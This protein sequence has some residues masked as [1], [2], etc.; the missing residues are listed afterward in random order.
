MC[1]ESTFYIDTKVEIKS[2]RSALVKV[3]WNFSDQALWIGAG[4]TKLLCCLVQEQPR[5]RVVWLA[6]TS[7]WK[8]LSHFQIFT[9]KSPGTATQTPSLCNPE[10]NRSHVKRS[11]SKTDA[12][13]LFLLTNCAYF[14]YPSSY[15][16]QSY[17]TPILHIPKPG[18]DFSC[19]LRIL[20][21]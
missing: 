7:F 8:L 4:L 12:T 17:L 21:R 14:S 3:R 6:W 10:R 5:R 20:P 1:K 19:I 13:C 11:W 18:E 15:R 9:Y 16:F 2:Y